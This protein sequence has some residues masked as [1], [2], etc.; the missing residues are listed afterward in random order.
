M[1]IRVCPKHSSGSASAPGLS[2]VAH[3]HRTHM[4]VDLSG[5]PPQTRY[6]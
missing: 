5:F 3:T 1:A 2:L 6:V 4:F